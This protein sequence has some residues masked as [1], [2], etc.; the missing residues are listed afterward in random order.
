MYVNIEMILVESIPGMGGVKEMWGGVNSSMIYLTHCKNFC[1][2][3]IVPPPST[4]LSTT[5]KK[6]KKKENYVA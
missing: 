3:H 4:K 2:C 1:K 6:K 5:K